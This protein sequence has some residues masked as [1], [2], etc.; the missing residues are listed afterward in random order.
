[1]N[2]LDKIGIVLLVLGFIIPFFVYT[3]FIIG[4]PIYIIGIITLLFGTLKIKH[5]LLWILLPLIL[6]YPT[7]KIASSVSFYFADIQ[8]IDL[9]LHTDFK[10]KAIIIDNTDFG[11]KFEKKNRREQILF[12]QNGIAFYPTELELDRSRFRVYTKQKNGELK[13]ILL[14]SESAEKT[15][16][17]SY[18]ESKFEKTVETEN[19][20]IPYD[21]VQIGESFND[22]NYADK[23]QE[24]IR[25]IK[26]GK[27]KTVYNKELS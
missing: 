10:G 26:E 23:R 17:L 1:M 4:L 27:L 22:H 16:L 6:F 14:S 24:L 20:Y 13:Q 18:G 21:F 25:L 11:Q 3:G 12:D 2:K 7:F 19:K 15:T 9:I 5:K 8:K